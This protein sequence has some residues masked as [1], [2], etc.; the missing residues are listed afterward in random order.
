MSCK[1]EN[2]GKTCDAPQKVAPSASTARLLCS[3]TLAIKQAKSLK[4]CRGGSASLAR[5]L[6]DGKS[7]LEPASVGP[8]YR[9]SYGAA[10]AFMSRTAG[11]KGWA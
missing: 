10:S 9:V 8:E 2:A 4:T 5:E 3:K 6:T 1:R 7:S 11:C